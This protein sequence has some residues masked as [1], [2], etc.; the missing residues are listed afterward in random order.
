VN[1]AVAAITGLP[2]EEIEGRKIDAL[3]QTTLAYKVFEHEMLLTEQLERPSLQ[4]SAIRT[5]A[6]EKVLERSVIAVQG[7]S[8]RPVGWMLVLR[9]VT[10][11]LR[12]AQ[13]R[14]LISETLI[15]DLR[16]PVSAVLGALEVVE[17][18]L[19]AKTDSDVEMSIQA[20]H[21]AR[22]GAQRV[23][24]LVDNLL[25]IARLQSGKIEL[26]RVQVELQKMVGV[27][28]NDFLPQSIEYGVILQNQIPTDW[29]TF[30]VDHTKITRVFTNLIDNALKYSPSGTPIVITG[31]INPQNTACIRI[32]DRGP[33]I[34]Q[35]YREMI[36][37]RFG[38]IP[39][40]RG[41]RRGTGL[42]LAFCK[43]A[44]EA[45]GGRIWVETN[46][47]GGSDFVFTL[48]IDDR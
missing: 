41:R 40:A 30:F 44:V 35:E 11:E 27:V 6:G 23:L 18:T 10:D 28:I 43:L 15:H 7:E 38:Q 36:F 1:N 26:T 21:V 42:G 9:D 32:S 31:E 25:D 3:T 48:P 14:E 16:S 34:P 24:D 4:R 5:P 2:L 22:R 17:T 13:E 33:G 46:A 47:H 29:P 19:P 39:G 12:M 20:L 8:D 37:E 45:H